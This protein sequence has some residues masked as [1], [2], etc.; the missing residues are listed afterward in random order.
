MPASGRPDVIPRHCAQGLDS[1]STICYTGGQIRIPPKTKIRS[2][3]RL[4]GV[5]RVG[6]RCEPD[7]SAGAEWT[8]ESQA[9]IVTSGG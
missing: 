8:W 7:T 1:R 9:E 6:A 5:Q 3:R 4:S 2:S